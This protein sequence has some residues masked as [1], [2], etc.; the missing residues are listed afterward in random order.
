M[1]EVL[2][3]IRP[4]K[5]KDDDRGPK[6]G[7]LLMEQSLA[8]IHALKNI[9]SLEIASLNGKIC[10]FVR[11]NEKTA[12]AVESQIYAQY[13]D[14]NVEQIDPKSLDITEE[15][16]S[17][18]L[19]LTLSHPDI[20]PI[21]RHPQFDD[22]LNRV[23]I[24]P[25]SGLTSTLSKYQDPK[26]RG[27]I[28]LKL[29]PNSSKFPRRVLR[30]LPLITK[31]LPSKYTW[32]RNIFA[33][34]H[35]AR[36][37][38]RILLLPLDVIMGGFRSWLNSIGD[39]IS[40]IQIAR[41]SK[42]DDTKDLDI[43]QTTRTHDREDELQASKDKMCRLL[44]DASITLRVIAPKGMTSACESKLQEISS[45]FRQFD[46]PQSNNFRSTKSTKRFL[47]SHEEA[48]T[49]W[50]LPTI[51][52]KTPNIDWVTNKQLE[53]PHELPILSE[54]DKDL[55]VL[56]ESVF[57]GKRTRFGI[58]QDDRR[59]HIYVIGKTGMGKSTILENM[60]FSDIQSGKG[61]AVIDP[62]GD[63]AES[64]LKMIPK[65][66]TNDVVL[67]DPTDRDYPISFNML[68][69]SNSDQRSLV[70]SGLMAVFTKIWPDVWSGRMEHILRNTLLA[71]LESP[72]SSMLGIMRMFAD[73]AYRKKVVSHL[74]DPLVKSFWEDEYEGW[75]EKYRTEAVAAIQNKIGQLLSTPIIRNIIGQ[76]ASSLDIRHAMDTGK[77]IIVNLSKG[78]L[79]EDN[80]AFLGS[81][82]V[83]KFQI[84]AMSRA[85]VP[86]S[87]RN[88][89]YLY[90][91]EFQNFATPSFASILSE[92]R[93]YRLNLTMANQYVSQLTP[94]K[95]NTM[96][97][98]AVFGNVGT[99]ITFQVG[100]E[101]AEEIASQFGDEKMAEDIVGLPKYQAYVKLMIEGIT[102]NPFSVA[103]LP[104]PDFAQ[105]K[106]R[107]EKIRKNSRERYAEKREEVEDKVRKWSASA[108]AARTAQKGEDKKKEKELEEIKKARK[109]GMKLD[110]YRKW[111][112]REMWTNSYNSLKKKITNG[113]ELSEEEKV[114]MENLKKRLDE[115]GGPT[116]EA[117]RKA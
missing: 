57:R 35:L 108:K 109:K 84:D 98:D 83:T 38:K 52:V 8:A 55:T 79:G 110:E 33:S 94:D 40:P 51:L 26:M 20:F 25:L 99:L 96:L 12:S 49:I 76:T 50:H 30:F 18:E 29:K 17:R 13:P 36:G 27:H 4:S 65:S 1:A 42:F 53:P 21:K 6:R 56:G 14:I 3:K 92:A 93:K 90:V 103:T 81:M 48:A 80:S 2:L 54:N 105:D 113:E 85:D 104:P 69:C 11:T 64:A 58:K 73:D 31:G 112:D 45:S 43:R 19:N 68:E 23:T 9:V 95:S 72:G 102:S 91:D 101:D 77:I 62:H 111:R 114:E 63:L 46:L 116:V 89:F 47:L 60:I 75:S 87:E 82:L 61:I 15:E 28:V 100:S 32:Y 115:G 37:I 88:D 5:T 39:I 59:R 16:E 117:A 7:P 71:L 70:A 66:R 24:D 44:F 107:T 106:G 67:F 10:F 22:M 41:D 34:V 97:R 86:E 74:S 78:K